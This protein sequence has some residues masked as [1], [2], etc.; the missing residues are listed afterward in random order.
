LRLS[1]V[2][3]AVQASKNRMIA[4]GSFGSAEELEE[5]GLL[6]M[7]LAALEE[8]ISLC[9]E[10]LLIRP[11]LGGFYSP[12][13]S[14]LTKQLS[15]KLNLYKALTT[16]TGVLYDISTDSIEKSI[17]GV[18]A[19]GEDRNT[20]I[21]GL[22]SKSDD[23]KVFFRGRGRDVQAS[24]DELRG[25]TKR[26][27]EAA[28]DLTTQFFIFYTDLVGKRSSHA[29]IEA[30]VQNALQAWFKVQTSSNTL[31]ELT[32]KKRE[33][34]SALIPATQTRLESLG[35]LEV[36]KKNLQVAKKNLAMQ[37][38]DSARRARKQQSEN[39]G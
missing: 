8:H 13:K 21:H 5:I 24:I 16:A 1:N 28:F 14:V 20:I 18:K 7:C 27:Q 12:N 17:A 3:S 29:V 31:R 19:V 35:Q 39:A 15:D 2:V 38:R 34:E 26:C 36:A 9:C 11:E 22:L 30:A 6:T 32:L 10:I 4:A 33:A 23:G 37:K 25:L